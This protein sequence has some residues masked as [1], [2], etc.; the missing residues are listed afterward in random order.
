MDPLC[1]HMMVAALGEQWDE[2]RQKFHTNSNLKEECTKRSPGDQCKLCDQC[3]TL[4]SEC[5]YLYHGAATMTTDMTSHKCRETFPY[6][7]LFQRSHVFSVKSH[8]TRLSTTI[9]T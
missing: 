8:S 2:H 7:V 9:G 6:N 4:H 3:V 5:K 1:K